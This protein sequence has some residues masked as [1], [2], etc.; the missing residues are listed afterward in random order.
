MNF[1]IHMHSDHS[2][3]ERGGVS[4]EASFQPPEGEKCAG[5]ILF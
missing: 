4:K 3:G 5:Q 1:G 2:R